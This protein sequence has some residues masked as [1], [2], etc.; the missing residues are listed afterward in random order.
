MPADS[1][2]AFVLIPHLNPSH[3]SKMV[4]LLS[5][6]TSMPVIEAEHGMV[7]E[8]NRLYIIPPNYFLAISH[9]K[10]QLCDPPAELGGQTS[11]D[12]F[13]RSLAVDQ[14]QRAIGIVLSGTGSHGSLGVR[15]IKTSGGM[16]MAQ[17]PDTAEYDQM[18]INAI[19]TGIV[20]IVLPP[21]QMPEAL[22]N[23]CVRSLVNTDVDRLEQ[24]EGSSEIIDQIFGILQT[25]ENYDFRAYRKPMVLRRI[26]RRMGIVGVDTLPTYLLFLRDRPEEATALFKDL[27]INVTSFFRDPEAYQVLERDIVPSLIANH[28]SHLPIRV[29][30]AGCST[31][32]EAYSI[33]IILRE[34]ITAAN[35]SFV[36]Q[37][38]A[39]DIDVDALEVARLG[40]YPASI[41]SDVSVER[42]EQFFFKCENEIYQI[43]K[44]IRD[45]VVFS[46]QNLIGD[47]PFSKLDLISC[48][49][50][51]IYFEQE[52]QKSVISLFHFALVAGGTL[53]LGPSE[54]IGRRDDLFETISKKW[55]VYR[56]TDTAKRESINLPMRKSTDSYSVFR[57][58]STPVV[59][60]KRLKDITEQLILSDHAPAV[61]LC[62]HALEVLYVTGPLVDFLEFPRGELT[63]DLLAMARPG[64]RTK[65]RATCRSAIREGKTV[66][67]VDVGVNRGG[68]STKCSI[69]ARPLFEPKEVAGL[70]LVLFHHQ[71]SVPEIQPNPDASSGTM[72]EGSITSQDSQLDMQLEIE[73]N[74]MSEELHSTIEEMESSN[75]ELKSSNEEIMSVNEELQSVNEE[76]E[77]SKEELQSLNEE[78]TTVNGQLLEKV[79]ELNRATSDLTNLMASTE[80][81]TIFLDQNLAIKLFTP[82]TKTLLNLLSTDIGRPLRDI[83]PN[84]PDDTMLNECRQVLASE[85]SVER[86]VQTEDLRYYLRRIL[87][88]RTSEN[89]IAGLVITFIDLTQRK[90]SEAAQRDSDARHFAELHES[91]ERMQ[92]I[93]NT[94]ADA[95]ITIDL[96]GTIDS[97]NLATG[98]MFHYDRAELIGKNIATLLPTL[99]QPDPDQYT[100]KS[101]ATKLI[102]ILGVRCEVQAQRKDKSFFPAELVLSRVDHFGLYTGILRDITVQKQLQSHV[103]EIATD[104]QLRIGQELHDGTQQEL[105]GLSLFAGALNDFL[106]NAT[107]NHDKGDSQWQLQ[108]ADYQR[109]RK[110]LEKLTQGLIEANHHVHKLSHGIM[111]IQ[112]DADGLQAALAHLA[113]ATNATHKIQC[114]FSF[115]GEGSIRSSAIATQL[116][117]IAQ[118]SLTNSIKHG[119]ASDIKIV[120]TESLDRIVLEISDNGI[121]FDP[122]KLNSDGLEADGLGLRIMRYRSSILGGELIVRRNERNGTTVRCSIP[123]QRGL[124]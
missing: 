64:L 7:V 73:L 15:Q 23:F 55:R 54:T 35:S 104:E 16:V 14:A 63:K 46:N 61:A 20:D 91:A 47:P 123:N 112:I 67:T 4:E 51:L 80:I 52:V 62:N 38:F 116:Y 41:A 28:S 26:Q 59:L 17:R 92:A 110:T 107:E 111:P 113:S 34:A 30:I 124:A 94:A 40:S 25:Q 36:I 100:A 102:E 117:R 45:S 32:E 57:P 101:I 81:A 105:T 6:W 71:D 122:Q 44:D 109:I 56:R 50:L 118:E 103:L 70:L 83:A 53:F 1:G 33:A 60:R 18:P 22:I 95:I 120:L 69:T 65:L 3:A 75:E 106:D 5:K 27:L 13:L 68:L 9:G 93:L 88:Y 90:K 29:W 85:V 72:V 2:M 119:E 11:I 96:A 82:P 24:A 66:R 43:N 98:Q 79:T 39:S 114:H 78:L 89:K 10:L 48:R 115:Q 12:F 37:L 42:L 99:F 74:S 108:D 49:N 121:G 86:E 76:L 21:E 8:V 58:N 19:K 87:P 97:I 77:S 84:F 31:G